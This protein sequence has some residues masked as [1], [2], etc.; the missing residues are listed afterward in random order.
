MPY[1]RHNLLCRFDP[2]E[3]L[4]QTNGDGKCDKSG[5]KT[6]KD[7]DPLHVFLLVDLGGVGLFM[8]QAVPKD[9]VG[10]DN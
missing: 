6:N 9:K 3:Q 5:K 2:L 10:N 8:K 4:Y 7:V 1:L